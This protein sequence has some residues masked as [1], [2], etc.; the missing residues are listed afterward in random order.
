MSTLLRKTYCECCD[1]GD[2]G[3]CRCG[4]KRSC[5]QVPSFLKLPN[6]EESCDAVYDLD[7]I[8]G[9]FIEFKNIYKFVNKGKK[10]DAIMFDIHNQ[11]SN[12]V[13]RCDKRFSNTKYFLAY[14]KNPLPD[15]ANRT[16]YNNEALKRLEQ[17][18]II[19]KAL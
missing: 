17:F 9:Y 11:L 6:H 12:A 5:R 15:K 8:T 3:I 2:K 18:Q 4:L 1:T 10:L 16:I 19:P 14:D 13:N 7:T